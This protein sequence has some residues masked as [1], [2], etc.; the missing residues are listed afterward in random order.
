LVVFG[1][2][3]VY[4]KNVEKGREEGDTESVG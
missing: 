3:I 1:L 4:I 2:H